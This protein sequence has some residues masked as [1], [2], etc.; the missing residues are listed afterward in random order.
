MNCIFCNIDCIRETNFGF[1]YY[2]T[3]SLCKTQFRTHSNIQLLT[4]WIRYKEYLIEISLETNKTILSSDNNGYKVLLMLN[5]V[6]DL[7]PITAGNWIDRMLNLK[8]F[9]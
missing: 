3:C 8:A 9:L 2:N 4:Y 7:T 1:K 5:Y 6:V